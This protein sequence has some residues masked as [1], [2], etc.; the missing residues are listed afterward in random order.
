V[1]GP[2]ELHGSEEIMVEGVG[3]EVVGDDLLQELAKAL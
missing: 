1:A 2:G 3:R